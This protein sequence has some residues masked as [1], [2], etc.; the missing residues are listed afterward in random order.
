MC[1]TIVDSS[2]VGYISMINKR[3]VCKKTPPYN[4]AAQFLNCWKPIY[5]L[6]SVVLTSDLFK[7]KNFETILLNEKLLDVAT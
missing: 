2:R 6:Y 1:L 3:D 5:N 7:R 4:I